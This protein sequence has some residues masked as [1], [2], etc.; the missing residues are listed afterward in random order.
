LS[1]FDIYAGLTGPKNSVESVLSNGFLL[2]NGLIIRST[3]VIPE[4]NDNEI[5]KKQKIVGAILLNN[6]TFE[7]DLS[8]NYEI[9]NNF[10]LKFN[11]KSLSIFRLIHPKPDLLV[12]GLGKKTRMLDQ[13]NKNF[14]KE[15]GIQLEVTSTLN[16][17]KNFDILSTER[18]DQIGALLLP[19]N[20]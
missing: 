7:I 20:V 12:I 4:N 18:K 19:P 14:F 5:N 13:S 2:T 3:N 11:E 6:E 10:I 8:N 1:K 9:I 17:C 15:L 16:A